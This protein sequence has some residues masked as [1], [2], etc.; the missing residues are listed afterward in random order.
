MTNAA[1]LAQIKSSLVENAGG[2]LR[3][4]VHIPGET[5]AKCRGAY[6]R[7]GCHTCYACEF[8]YGPSCADLVGSIVYGID[9]LQSGKLMFGYKNAPQSPV[10]IQRVSS[11]VAL[12][13]RGH[14]ACAGAL[15]GPAVTHWATVPS[16]RNIGSQHPFRDILSAI[17]PPD[18]EIEVGASQTAANKSAQDRRTLNPAFYELKTAVPKGVHVMVIDDTWT[19]GAHIQSVAMALKKAGAA[20]VSALAVARWL[21]SDERSRR[22]YNQHIRPCPYNPE[23]CPW[24]G[25]GCPPRSSSN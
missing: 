8:I 12:A 9:G 18:R 22:V 7:D 2:Y 19:S 1:A 4:T 17:L 6:M 15:V 3:N 25:A 16:L 5:C 21:D 11:L 23:I 24:T 10:L 14:I 13:L 20:K